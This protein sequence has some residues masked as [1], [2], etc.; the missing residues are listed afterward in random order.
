V[1]PFGCGVLV[2]L[3]EEDRGKFKSRCALMVFAHYPQVRSIKAGLMFVM[4]NSFITEE[5]TNDQVEELWK[6]FTPDL[7]R[8]K[9]SYEQD[10]WHMNPT[11][12]C[13]WCPVKSCEHF[14]ER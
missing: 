10:V 14:K 6:H 3:K 8:L 7:E 2:L 11:P 4:H 12:L 9:S 5:Y 13:G 1:V